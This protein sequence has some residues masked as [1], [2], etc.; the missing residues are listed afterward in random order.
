ME[1]ND[2]RHCRCSGCG[3]IFE[4]DSMISDDANYTE[5]CAKCFLDKLTIAQYNAIYDCVVFKR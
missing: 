5:L 2:G 4:I 1:S 3:K